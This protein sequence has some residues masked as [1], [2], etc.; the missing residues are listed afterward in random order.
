MQCHYED[1]EEKPFIISHY[2]TAAFEEPFSVI[3]MILN[4]I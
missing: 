3:E 1:I 2:I 4:E